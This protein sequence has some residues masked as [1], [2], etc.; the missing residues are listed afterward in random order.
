[1]T[2]TVKRGAGR[3][4]AAAKTAKAAQRSPE[5][6]A[7]T[8][9]RSKARNAG[10][11]EQ[12]SSAEKPEETLSA[13]QKALRT[14]RANE[15]AAQRTTPEP[16]AEPKS[17]AELP[18]KVAK[19]ATATRGARRGAGKAP[20]GDLPA[21]VSN[22]YPGA[23]KAN[24]LLGHC[25]EHGWSASATTEPPTS[26]VVRAERGSEVI[27]VAFIDNKLDL[28]RMPVLSR[29]DRRDVQLKNVSAAKKIIEGAA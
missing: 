11:R 10:I 1:M 22:A 24:G 26:I 28:S 7:A 2:V 12:E 15:R 8:A 27:V 17:G 14:R 18:A 9:T 3:P 5:S 4:A 6:V 25:V 16:V 29:P 13:S 23:A 21:L 20:A 19:P